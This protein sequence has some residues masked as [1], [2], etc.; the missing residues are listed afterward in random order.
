MTFGGLT[1]A[2]KLPLVP[3]PRGR[4]TAFPGP[5]RSVG[6]CRAGGAARRPSAR[7]T[8]ARVAG[9]TAP[10]AAR[11]SHPPGQ[12]SW[13]G[14]HPWGRVHVLAPSWCG[15]GEGRR[16]TCQPPGDPQ[17]RCV[18]DG[19]LHVS[20]MPWVSPRPMA[21]ALLAPADA[22]HTMCSCGTR[23]G[24]AWALEVYTRDTETYS[25][26][27]TG[28]RR[29]PTVGTAASRG[30]GPRQPLGEAAGRVWWPGLGARPSSPSLGLVYPH[31]S[32]RGALT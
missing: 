15:G 3:C 2:G 10:S 12:G 25:R 9:R 7:A 22:R 19:A 21:P 18:G 24:K 27:K 1:L 8:D 13:P 31:P 11:G 5:P 32:A 23:P 4:L 20:P 6:P 17:T 16:P 29:T 28:A 26:R 14:G 30:R